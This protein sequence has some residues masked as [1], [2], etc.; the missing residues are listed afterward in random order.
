MWNYTRKRINE[1][2]LYGHVLGG[3]LGVGGGVLKNIF[4][5]CTWP[6]QLYLKTHQQ[7]ESSPSLV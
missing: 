3:G 5:G 7:A 2:V 4:T 1:T 6:P